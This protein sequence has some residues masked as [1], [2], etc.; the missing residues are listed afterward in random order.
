MLRVPNRNH[1]PG[2]R[3]SVLNIKQANCKRS[4]HRGPSFSSP[5]LSNLGPIFSPTKNSSNPRLFSRLSAPMKGLGC[6]WSRVWLGWSWREELFSVDV[7]RLPGFERETCWFQLISTPYL[8]C[9]P[10]FWAIGIKNSLVSKCQRSI[11]LSWKLQS[12]SFLPLPS[13]HQLQYGKMSSI[14][15]L[16]R[17]KEG[18]REKL[19]KEIRFDFPLAGFRG[20]IHKETN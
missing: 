19:I 10:S 7:D 1:F 5:G 8:C 9:F 11:F 6:Q 12:R 20:E 13:S 18:K 15:W 2:L 17:K 14:F 3:L 16:D 4:L